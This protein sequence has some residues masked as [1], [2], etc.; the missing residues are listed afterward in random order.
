[1][2]LFV[3]LMGPPSAAAGVGSLKAD[4]IVSALLKRFE[5]ELGRGVGEVVAGLLGARPAL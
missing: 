2:E 4:K 1:M 5:R 3:R